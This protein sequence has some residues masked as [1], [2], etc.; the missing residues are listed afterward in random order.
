MIGSDVSPSQV[1]QGTWAFALEEALG[2]DPMCLCLHKSVT[3]K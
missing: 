1:V 3:V 2:V